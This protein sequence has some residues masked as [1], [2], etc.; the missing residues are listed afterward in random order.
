LV[1]S[2]FGHA[3]VN[4]NRL[5]K[6]RSK[7]HFSNHLAP[8][9]HLVP[10]IES[11]NYVYRVKNMNNKPLRFSVYTTTASSP[12]APKTAGRDHST[13]TDAPALSD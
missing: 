9:Q 11:S 3:N 10:V 5:K 6:E 4:G 8:K 13:A 1:K 2:N 7:Y 12:T